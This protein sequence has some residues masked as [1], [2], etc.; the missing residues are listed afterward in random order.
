MNAL[1]KLVIGNYGMTDDQERVHMAM[2]AMWSA[3][4]IMSNDLRSVKRSSKHLLLNKNVIRIN[5][6]EL[7]V[8]ARIVIEVITT[9]DNPI[10]IVTHFVDA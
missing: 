5:Q 10:F 3:P 9:R 8:Q 2:W 4:L 7:G 6:D 1:V